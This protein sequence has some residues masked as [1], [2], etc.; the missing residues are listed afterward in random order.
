MQ[1]LHQVVARVAVGIPPSEALAP[2]LKETHVTTRRWTLLSGFVV[3]GVAA[4]LSGVPQASADDWRPI[5]P[6]ELKMTSELLAPGAPAIMLYHQVDRDD[7][8]RATSE[9]QYVRIKILTEEGR[10]YADVEIPF[11]K[12]RFKVDGLS[13]RTI[14]PDGS[15][16]NFSGKVFE[17]TI[18]KSKTFKY[19][20][21]TFTMPDVS[22]GSI[23]EY[24]Y[25]YNF[26][27]NYIFDSRWIISS[28]LFTKES[29]FS[30]KP[31]N[32]DGYVLHWM[33]PAGLPQGAA[34]PKQDQRGVIRMTAPN[35]PAFQ[36][37]DYMPPEN[38][39]KYRVVFVYNLGVPEMNVE[40]YWK[41]YDKK[42]Y[43]AVEHFVGKHKEMEA[44]V[45]QIVS[46]GDAPE[47]KVQKIYSRVQLVR[48][49]DFEISKTEA[50][51]KREK[52]KPA[53][54]V[55]DVWKSGSGSGYD[56]TWLF[57][58]L[59]RAAGIEAHPCMISNRNEY[60]FRKER[61]NSAELT[62]NVVLVKLN[63]KD[64]YAD[65][66]AAYT[67]F[68]LLPWSETGVTGLE[69]DK[70]GG[71]WI[72]TNLPDSNASRIERSAD[73]KL[74]QEGSLEGK[75]TITY[76]G[77]EASSRRT[78]ERHEDETGR[79]KYLEDEVK[80]SVPVGTEVDLT[81]KPD[82]TSSAITMVA[83][84]DLKVPG[85]IT[86]AGRRAFFPTGLFGADEKHMFEHSTRVYP[87][88]FQ[89][90][91]KKIDDLKVELPLGWQVGSVPKPI[92]QDAKAAEFSLKV[93]G[94]KGALHIHRELR[95]DLTLV[96]VN[97]YPVLRGFYQT[98]Q[99]EDN[100]Q[101]VLQPGNASAGN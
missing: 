71:A 48:N 19:V 66:G 82:W 7:S 62:S 37:E 16:V 45:A 69:L 91:F 93:E 24:R 56:I 90:P 29:V 30:L 28:D 18:V 75:L 5:T 2:N 96:G 72:Q 12:N 6:E 35:V 79:K 57:L 32:D 22:V 38:E 85:W 63:G 46:P 80:E 94:D 44:A 3:L 17:N 43:D 64:L 95:S 11:E 31:Y 1:A 92:D 58:G 60:F 52:I 55:A 99:S 98:V 51:E 25:H 53:D 8:G 77:L 88:Y 34:E 42:R 54:N 70:D 50:E 76:S 74:T 59:V 36:T 67:P 4:T 33:W 87:I 81:N 41:Q 26:Q 49:L 100:Q 14:H 73:L 9:F 10:K 97:L 27:D 78:E 39:L 23:I 61:I 65:P 15:I 101:V 47:V 20:A 89:Y 83:V 86:G 13:A 68:G 40:K 21:K 84:Y